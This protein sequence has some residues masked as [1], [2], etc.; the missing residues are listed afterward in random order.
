[1]LSLFAVVLYIRIRFTEYSY[2]FAAVIALVHDVPT[3]GALAIAIQLNIIN[4]QVS[5]V[6][7]AF[8]TIIGYSLN[9]TIVVFDR[10]RENLR[11]LGGKKL[12]RSSTSPSTRPWRG[13]S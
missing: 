6:M 2:G 5:L 13:R 4:A 10:I 7:I 3:L 11:S 8:L 9:D 1:M 12:P